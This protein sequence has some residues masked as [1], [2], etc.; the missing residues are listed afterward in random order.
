MGDLVVSEIFRSIDGEGKR[1]GL[2]CTFVRLVGCNLR[3]SYCDTA[4]AFTSDGTSEELGLDDIV[5]RVDDL[6]TKAVT[7]TGGEPLLHKALALELMGR[8]DA[9]GHEV[10]VETNGAIALGDVDRSRFPH[11][12]LTMD[13]KSPSSGMGGFMDEGNLSL[14]RKRDV[15]KFVVGSD[16][17]L[18]DM[19]HV[20]DTH[21][22]AAQVF[23]SPVW[24]EMD[25]RRMTEYVLDNRIDARVQMQLHKLIW[26]PKARGV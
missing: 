4:Y 14:L 15:L 21:E 13:W 1:A 16:D 11:A 8:L 9:G 26:D 5:R 12:F 10:N 18:A 3:C 22:V 17:D 6:G 25:L 2:P 20:L 24:G 23:V 19:S 7:L